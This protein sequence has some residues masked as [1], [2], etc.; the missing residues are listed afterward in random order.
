MKRHVRLNV[1]PRDEKA[2][3]TIQELNDD[4]LTVLEG[5]M[6]EMSNDVLFYSCIKFMTTALCD[7]L[8]SQDQAVKIL[9]MA[10]EDGMRV[11]IA[12]RGD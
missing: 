12:G 3:Q 8:E 9:K 2:E 11:A 10:T 4:L 6:D 5:H 1:R 7:C